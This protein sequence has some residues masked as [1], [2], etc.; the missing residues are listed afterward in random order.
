[1]KIKRGWL[2]VVIVSDPFIRKLNF[3][4]LKRDSP[5][6][7]LAFG[8]DVQRGRDRISGEVVISWDTARRV[9]R[10]YAKQIEE[11]FFLYLIHG[12][13]HLKGYTDRSLK[14]SRVM[15]ERQSKILL[16]LLNEKKQ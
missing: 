7:V 6:D 2:N 4:F 16:E 3:R 14:E 11:E 15:E 10:R 9:A 1:M 12:I 8:E 5:T 13:L